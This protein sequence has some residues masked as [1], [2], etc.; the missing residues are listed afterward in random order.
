LLPIGFFAFLW[1]TSRQHRGAFDSPIGIGAIVTGL[2]L[3]C[4]AC[5]IRFS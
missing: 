3:E 2:M 4:V 1:A 5:W